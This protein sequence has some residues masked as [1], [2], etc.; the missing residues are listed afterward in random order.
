MFNIHIPRY[1]RIWLIAGGV[2]LAIFLA[3]FALLAVG[4]S[5]EPP[6]HGHLGMIDP[7][8]VDVTPPF[9]NPGIREIGPNEYEVD[10]ISRVFSFQP[11]DIEIPAGA[12]VYFRVTSPDVVHGILIAGTNVNLM[13]VPGHITEFAYTFK[14]PG[15]Y[16]ILC[17]EYCG[18]GHHLMVGSVNV[19]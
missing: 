19:L 4:M 3:L 5:L 7:Q 15:Q 11:A 12:K 2:T 1:E 10:M 14:K 8:Q 17:H 9:D 18:V 6:G 13:A 16:L